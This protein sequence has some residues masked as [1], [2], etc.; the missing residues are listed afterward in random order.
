MGI[1]LIKSGQLEEAW[2]MFGMIIRMAHSIRLHRDPD[3]LR[4]AL[5]PCERAVRRRIWWAILH[6][7]QYLSTILCRPLGI[8]DAGSCAP[9]RS[10]ATNTVELRLDTVLIESTIATREI[11]SFQGC[12]NPDKIAQF[13]RR[14]LSLWHT[15]PETLRFEESWFEANYKLPEWPLDILSAS[16]YQHKDFRAL[17]TILTPSRSLCR[18]SIP[19]STAQQPRRHTHL[20]NEAHTTL[21]RQRKT[22]S[23]SRPQDPLTPFP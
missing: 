11:L 17:S 6:L 21:A 20:G 5:S 19:D 4:L 2:T 9:P 23:L 13:T 12:A 8:P 22:S 10:L 16:S 18:S 1:C 3:T 14:L 15:M 7:D